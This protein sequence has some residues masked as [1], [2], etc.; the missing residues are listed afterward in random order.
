MQRFEVKKGDTIIK[1]GDDGDKFYVV[2]EGRFDVF[3][4]TDNGKSQANVLTYNGQGSF[5]ELSLMYGKPRAATIVAQTNGVLWSLERRAFRRLVMKSS[6]KSLMGTLKSVEILKSLKQTQ[7][8][9]LADA[10]SEVKYKSGE[11]VITQGEVG[12]KFFVIQKGS[13]KC[14]V[15]PGNGEKAKEV[16]RLGAGSYFG[17][18]ALLSNNPRAASVIAV[19]ALTCL[20]ISREAFENV[21]GPLASLIEEDQKR[22]ESR[23]RKVTRKASIQVKGN[24]IQDI[25]QS[26][27]FDYS[28]VDTWFADGGGFTNDVSIVRHNRGKE[29]NMRR[30]NKCNVKNQNLSSKVLRCKE[31]MASLGASN[32]SNRNIA[33]L[34]ATYVDENC[35]WMLLGGSVPVM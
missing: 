25:Q 34:L 3:V 31:L 18:R 16:L 24:L 27:H 15:D 12:E 28:F 35:L 22:R 21:L 6:A 4:T 8:V 10:L 30:F 11:S 1:Q 19:S 20:Q 26:S 14:V 33:D 2:D 29:F 32:N 9:A 5:G 17:E 7:I 13:V 23:G